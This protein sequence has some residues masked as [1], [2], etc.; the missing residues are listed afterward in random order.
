MVDLFCT[1]FV[2]MIQRTR[3][4]F[5]KQQAIFDL[6][7]QMVQA[8]GRAGRA[9]SV[10]TVSRQDSG[11]CVGAGFRAAVANGAEPRAFVARGREDHGAEDG[12]GQ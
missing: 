8:P 12:P 9:G 7:A 6:P 4:E 1:P 11:E 10:G 3:L 2:D 5:R